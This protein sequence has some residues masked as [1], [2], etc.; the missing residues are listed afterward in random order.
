[1]VY[2]NRKFHDWFKSCVDD[3]DSDDREEIQS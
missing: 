1:M 3:Y 2:R